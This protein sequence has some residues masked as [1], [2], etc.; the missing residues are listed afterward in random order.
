MQTLAIKLICHWQTLLIV[1]MI[2]ALTNCSKI[3]GS[4]ELR[5]GSGEPYSFEGA[6]VEVFD[7]NPAA[8]L[9]GQTTGINKIP[10]GLGN[11]ASADGVISLQV[12]TAA[13]ED[14][15]LYDIE[16]QCPVNNTTDTCNVESTLHI[17]VSGAQLMA[18][19]W[20]ATALSD[21]VFH[22]VAYYAAVEYSVAEIA[23]MLDNY[24]SALLVGAPPP[25]AAKT[26]GD[27]LTWN[28][29]QTALVK[30][31]NGLET[32][33]AALAE[34]VDSN[35]IKLKARQLVGPYVS[36]L[37]ITNPNSPWYYSLEY[38]AATNGFA[39]IATWAG[40]LKIVDVRNQE[41]PVLAST[42]L[43]TDPAAPGPVGPIAAAGNFVYLWEGSFDDDE[44]HVIDVSD[45]VNPQR[46]GGMTFTG[47][48]AR[49]LVVSGNFVYV[50]KGGSLEVV[51]V[52]NPSAP[53]LA[54]SVPFGAERVAV[55]GTTAYIAGLETLRVVDLGNP[56][57][58]VVLGSVPEGSTLGI[59][60]AGNHVYSLGLE[61]P[62]PRARVLNVIDVSNPAAPVQVHE[63]A[64]EADSL[65]LSGS[66]LYLP[67]EGDILIFDISNP[68]APVRTGILGS[69][70]YAAKIAAAENDFIYMANSDLTFS[71]VDAT[72]A[73]Q[74]VVQSATLAIT[75]RGASQHMSAAGNYAILSRTFSLFDLSNPLAPA[76]LTNF[77]P[78]WAIP[79]S[80][81]IDGDYVFIGDE[82]RGSL[83]IAN[84]SDPAAPYMLDNIV[85]LHDQAEP[86]ILNGIG[87]IVLS[88]DYVY[89]PWGHEY[90]TSGDENAPPPD[91][92]Y[93]EWG[94][95]APDADSGLGG[96]FA[97]NVS[98]PEA[99]FIAGHIC[100]PE[101]ADAVA[102]NGRYA[103]VVVADG[104]LQVVDFNDPAQ[105]ALVGSVALSAIANAVAVRGNYVW[106][107][108]GASGF[109]IVNVSNPAAPVVVT[110][111]DTP[112]HA[113]SVSFDDGYAYMADG[114]SGIL[115]FDIT[116]PALPQLVASASTISDASA[117]FSLNNYLFTGTGYGIEVFR[118]LPV[119]P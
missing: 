58:P 8:V 66:S 45:P 92:F 34:G 10:K 54:G 117:L 32:I 96:L 67:H 112:G 55:Q 75:P 36:A 51:D 46:V 85:Y 59:T 77:Q 9:P 14:D 12:I 30:R 114:A 11:I 3:E 105:P 111:S 107:S 115:M 104:S 79:A 103:Y 90:I 40:E 20:K 91:D 94:C 86:E 62:P 27:L 43:A 83:Q 21:I 25:A 41:Q 5:N 81:A 89:V 68:V 56:A 97:I 116:T 1:A 28:P 16:I 61:G 33:S 98:S 47:G 113:S 6:K 52:S 13:I 39:Y 24:A 73:T 57:A 17:V 15:A 82:N 118:L 35:D 65:T 102:V 7:L 70:G 31:P 29:S 60:A 64:I 88:A 63:L 22:N 78:G 106:V 49:Q 99:S 93:G 42:Y 4:A 72:I 48:S 38:I 74:S 80:T 100:M 44:L 19:G 95:V 110:G 2:P 18:G 50:A 119:N 109:E 71:V 26:Y 87:P 37:A 53:V 23:Q 69:S 101:E 76:L 84:I 108:E